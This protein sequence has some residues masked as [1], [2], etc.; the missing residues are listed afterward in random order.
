ML[1]RP[2]SPLDLPETV[3][4]FPLT[5]ALLLPFA[6]RPLNVFEPRYVDMVDQALRGDRLI[7]LIQPEDASEEES[8]L[9]RLAL[10][11]IGC[12]GRITHFEDNDD[13]YF[14]ILDGICRFEALE[15]LSTDTAYRQ[16]AISFHRVADYHAAWGGS[17][18]DRV[19]DQVHRYLQQ[20]LVVGPQE[21]FGQT[22]LD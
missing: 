11:K 8:P 20:A 5:G 15:E 7:G 10:Q 19:R 9:E 18:F 2:A 12:L 4:V 3:P 13:R 22:G 1:K 17:V 6:Q 14:I 16:F 21:E